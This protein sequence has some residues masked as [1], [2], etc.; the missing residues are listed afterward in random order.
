M[1][2]VDINSDAIKK[3]TEEYPYEDYETYDHE[4]IEWIRTNEH[5]LFEGIIGIW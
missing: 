3:I 4:L 2:F 5:Q 1:T